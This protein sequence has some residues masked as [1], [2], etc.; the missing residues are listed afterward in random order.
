M[1]SMT[2]FSGPRVLGS[3]GGV[4][5]TED[6]RTRGPED[7]MLLTRAILRYGNTTSAISV[8]FKNS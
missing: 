1:R 6:P 7:P 3:S 2:G 8:N 4:G 5:A